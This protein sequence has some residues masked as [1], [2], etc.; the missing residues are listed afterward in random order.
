MLI[1]STGAGRQHVQHFMQRTT[2]GNGKADALSLRQPMAPINGSYQLWKLWQLLQGPKQSIARAT[3]IAHSDRTVAPQ[4]PSD[5]SPASCTCAHWCKRLLTS[6]CFKTEVPD[7]IQPSIQLEIRSLLCLLEVDAGTAPSKSGAQPASGCHG[8]VG[9]CR[10]HIGAQDP[11]RQVS[12]AP[13]ANEAA[14]DPALCCWAILQHPH[15]TVTKLP[16]CW[17]HA[18][19]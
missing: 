18:V 4:A 10:T 12:H 15:G 13:A 16:G 5:E 14:D 7:S 19:A 3:K 9:N 11:V 6:A 1:C 8:G 17:A 2:C